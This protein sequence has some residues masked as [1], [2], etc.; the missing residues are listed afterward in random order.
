MNVRDSNQ[1]ANAAA[2]FPGR[3][4]HWVALTAAVFTWPLL[5]S[6]GEV[7][8][9]KVGMAVPDWPSTFGENMFLYD[10][11][12]ASVG[13]YKEHFHRLMGASLGF[14]AIILAVRAYRSDPRRWMKLAGVGALAAVCF[15]GVIGGFRVRLNSQSF[16]AFHACSGQAVFAYLVAVAVWTGP[17]W[18]DAAQRVQDDE[19]LRRKS[20]V[21]LGLVY[22]Q[23]VL[24]AWLRHFASPLAA[25]V[26]ALVAVGVLGSAGLLIWRVERSRPTLGF[27]IPAARAMAVILAVQVALGLAAFWILLPFDGV[28]KP[29]S[30]MSALVRTGHQANGA[31]LLA[32]AVVLSLRACRGLE[33]NV[34]VGS[35]AVGTTGTTT[36]LEAIV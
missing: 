27:M 23:I 18:W 33:V 1:T 28:P 13:V 26:H 19:H 4:L 30:T 5:I 25:T 21:T 31:L 10:F 35:R 7:T 9:Y 29:V 14:L 34:R 2:A 17:R 20:V 16:A 22:L 6:G 11:W 24:G 8:T 15:Q 36:G 3:G 32:S 12:N